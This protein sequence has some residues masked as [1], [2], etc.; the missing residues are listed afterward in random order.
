MASISGTLYLGVTNNLRR[1]V[2]EHKNKLFEGFSKKYNCIK[3]IYFEEYRNINDTI[4]REKQIKNW[5]R[6]KK[7]SLIKKLNP[8]WIDLSNDW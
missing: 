8:S 5:N 7:E 4:K 6:N 2:Y 3:L 1:R